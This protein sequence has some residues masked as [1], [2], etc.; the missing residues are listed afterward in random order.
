MGIFEDWRDGLL[1]DAAALRALTRELGEV[2][3]ELEPL[4]A[5]EAALREQLGYILAKSGEGRTTIAGFGTLELT[6]PSVTR[7]YDTRSID[8]LVVELTASAPELAARLASY[9]VQSERAG[10]LRITRE[11][12]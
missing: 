3:S 7:R 2:T 9:C 6:A 5:Q 11:K 4:K 1:D 8:A 12:K 10:G